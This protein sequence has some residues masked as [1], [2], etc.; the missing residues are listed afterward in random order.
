MDD[1]D[2]PCFACWLDDGDLCEPRPSFIN[3]QGAA[4]KMKKYLFVM[5]QEGFPWG[6]SE[7]LWSS[8]AEHLVR[9]GNEVRV[10][11][12]DWGK[13][14]PQIEHLRSAGC[15][16]FPRPDQ[17]KIPP[18]FV[19]Q[20]RRIFPPP[21]ITESHMAAAG[22]DVDLVVVCSPDN[23]TGLE[24]MESASAAGRKYAVIAQSA[25]VYWWPNDDDAERLAESYE[26]ASGAYFVSQGILEISRDQFGSP[27]S[28]AK[29]VRNPF[30]VRYDACP[31]WPASPDGEL[32]LACVGRVDVISKG[33]DLLLQVLGLPH[34]RQRKVR[35]SVFG[36]GPNERG[37]RR[38]AERLG[39]KNVTFRGQLNDVEA[40][41]AEHHALV[42]PSRFEGMPLVVMEAM[43][44]GRPCIAT[45]VGGNR[46]LIR[47]GVNGFLAKAPTVELLDEAM[48][49]A[50]ENRSRL[51]A[52][53]DISARDVRQWVSAD[54]GGDLAR[55]LALLAG[56]QDFKVE[57]R[58]VSAVGAALEAR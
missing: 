58:D 39:L 6:G 8:A 12:K 55:E 31:P 1:P 47:D 36:E 50:W 46:E 24:W 9:P 44:C 27:L 41:W 23:K 53:G 35:L 20:Y 14:V 28:N 54:P 49:R 22:A 33:Q 4:V 16:I 52:M 19:R 37:L 34:W 13:A 43:L 29:V 17:Y 5:A 56:D 45:D 30:N 18:F 26:K 25:V 3:D 21:P 11:V 10:S 42:L 48:N 15:K 7:P 32:A 2:G 57:G 51:R 40:I 38:M